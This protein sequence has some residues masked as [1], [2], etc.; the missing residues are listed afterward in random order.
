MKD[1]STCNPILLASHPYL[2][3]KFLLIKVFRY[4]LYLGLNFDQWTPLGMSQ[5]S[6]STYYLHRSCIHSSNSYHPTSCY[7]KTP[8]ISTIPKR[9]KIKTFLKSKNRQQHNYK[10]FLYTKCGPFMILTSIY[11]QVNRVNMLTM[12]TSTKN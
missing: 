6:L 9:L 8:Q 3:Y 5:M 4:L 2:A 10:S 11:L 7:S 1:P 12:T